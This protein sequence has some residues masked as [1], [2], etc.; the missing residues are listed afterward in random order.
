MQFQLN[1]RINLLLNLHENHDVG[2]KQKKEA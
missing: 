1:G 2:N